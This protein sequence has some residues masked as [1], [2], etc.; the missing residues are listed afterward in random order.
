MDCARKFALCHNGPLPRSATAIG[1]GVCEWSPE[2]LYDK[3]VPLIL[4]TDEILKLVKK[5]MN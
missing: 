3:S 4:N 1:P 5:K 2:E